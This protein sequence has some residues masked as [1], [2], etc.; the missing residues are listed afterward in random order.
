MSNYYP[1]S[2]VYTKTEVDTLIEN[3][4]ISE[5]LNAVISD[6]DSKIATV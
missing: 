2:D 3:V 1:K 6:T 4:D 5:E